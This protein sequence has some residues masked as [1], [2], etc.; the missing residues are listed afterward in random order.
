MDI[1]LDTIHELHEAVHDRFNQEGVEIAFP[2]MD[3][4]VRSVDQMV[5]LPASSAQVREKAA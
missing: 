5:S 3:L 1:R 4:H 2:Q